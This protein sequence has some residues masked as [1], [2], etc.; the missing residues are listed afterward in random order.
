MIAITDIEKSGGYI[1]VVLYSTATYS[2]VSVEHQPLSS[3]N[4]FILCY[5]TKTCAHIV[6]TNV[7]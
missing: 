2:P 7:Y 4:F 6:T 5:F 1:Y 3:C